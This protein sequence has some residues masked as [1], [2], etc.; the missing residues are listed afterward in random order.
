[1]AQKVAVPLGSGHHDSSRVR[2]DGSLAQAAGRFLASGRLFARHD[3][4]EN[5]LSAAERKRPTNADSHGG[6]NRPPAK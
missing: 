5:S 3:G 1:M 6:Q 2:N 4:R